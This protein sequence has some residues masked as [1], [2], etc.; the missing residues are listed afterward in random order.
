M[1][2][3]IKLWAVPVNLVSDLKPGTLTLSSTAG[4]ISIDTQ[5]ESIV[6]AA[7][8]DDNQSAG[9]FHPIDIT[10][11]ASGRTAESYGE[12]MN[13][14]GRRYIIVAIDSNEKYWCYGNRV[15]AMKFSFWE[16]PGSDTADFSY[17]AIRFKCQCLTGGIEVS[18][19]F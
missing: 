7:P 3:F 18:K 16:E 17:Y 15:T 5:P 9:G 14:L 2:G 6:I 12:F 1:G 4:V 19:P 10:A 13:M 8:Y 11:K